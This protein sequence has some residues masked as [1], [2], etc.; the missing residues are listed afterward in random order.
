MPCFGRVGYP[1]LGY[2]GLG[3]RL[4][5]KGPINRA[6]GGGPSSQRDVEQTRRPNWAWLYRADSSQYA[7]CS[8]IHT[9]GHREWE[10]L[11]DFAAASCQDVPRAAGAKCFDR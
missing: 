1:E 7:K 10:T 4:A 5:A 3:A 2:D 6:G 11:V 8:V 9:R